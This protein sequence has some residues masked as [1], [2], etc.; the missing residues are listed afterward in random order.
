MENLTKAKD[1]EVTSAVKSSTYYMYWETIYEDDMLPLFP[2]ISDYF[3][4]TV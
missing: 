3:F 1:E 4:S 2:M